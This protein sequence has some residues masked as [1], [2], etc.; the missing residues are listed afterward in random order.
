MVADIDV[1][2]ATRQRIGGCANMLRFH[3]LDGD[4]LSGNCTRHQKCSSLNPVRDYPVLGSMQGSHSF[5]E[6][7]A[8][9]RAF[10]LRAHL[11]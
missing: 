1:I 9:S 2:A 3:S 7:P 5:D 10:D 4:S 6:D 8:R 11:V